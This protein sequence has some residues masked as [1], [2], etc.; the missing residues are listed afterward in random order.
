MKVRVKRRT[1][2]EPRALINGVEQVTG[3]AVYVVEGVE[4]DTRTTF[5]VRFDTDPTD[6]D[7]VVK[8][9]ELIGDD[10]ADVDPGPANGRKALFDAAAAAAAK[11]DALDRLNA[12][13]QDPATGATNKQKAGSQ[14]LA[15]RAYVRAR[16]LASDYADAVGE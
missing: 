9:R 12:K 3:P 15:D 4:A 7:I 11:W 14:A 13:V 1:T 10:G 5:A 16:R 2:V 6:A 8:V